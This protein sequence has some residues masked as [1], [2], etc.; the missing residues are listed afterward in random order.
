[1]QFYIFYVIYFELNKKKPRT[2]LFDNI[3]PIC[4]MEK[5]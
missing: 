5:G 4:G 3:Q 2:T 1:M